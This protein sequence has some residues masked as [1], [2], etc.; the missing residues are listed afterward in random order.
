MFVIMDERLVHAQILYHWCKAEP[1]EE[2]W[3]LSVKT[4][5]D[6]FKKMLIDAMVPASLKLQW[7]PSTEEMTNRYNLC[8]QKDKVLLVVETLEDLCAVVENCSD[9]IG[10]IS[11]MLAKKERAKTLLGLYMTQDEAS[12]AKQHLAHN[13]R[14]RYQPLPDF[15]PQSLTE[16]NL[17]FEEASQ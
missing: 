11:N 7:L 6:P 9:S 1:I 5:A 15:E 4:M 3:V 10:V 14:Y 12:F 2:L 13:S 16:N 17:K 8:S